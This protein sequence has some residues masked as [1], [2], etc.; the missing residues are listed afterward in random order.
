MATELIT[1][2]MDSKL[3]KEVDETAK[4]AGY[5]NRTEMIRS[6]LRKEID[7]VKLKHAMKELSY[8]KGASNKKITDEDLE[9]IRTR[10]F[11]EFDKKIR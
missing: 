3:L 11:E 5:H 7:E 2:K 8:L 10:V 9:R 6:A 4:I 1:F